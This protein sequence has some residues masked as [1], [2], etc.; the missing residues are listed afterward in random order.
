MSGCYT[1]SSDAGVGG[2]DYGK[3]VSVS[4][5]NDSWYY[6]AGVDDYGV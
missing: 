5:A 4:G 3:A 2:T 1:D 6:V